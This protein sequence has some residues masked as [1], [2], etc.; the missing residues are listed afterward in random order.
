MIWWWFIKKYE[1]TPDLGK[2]IRLTKGLYVKYT[3]FTEGSMSPKYR[4]N[5]Y[6]GEDSYEIRTYVPK[7]AHTL[8]IS[9]NKSKIT[10]EING[11]KRTYKLKTPPV[12]KLK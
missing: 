9:R 4:F 3:V 1:F 12:W 10:L 7:N 6:V 8:T 5:V 11:E 2:L